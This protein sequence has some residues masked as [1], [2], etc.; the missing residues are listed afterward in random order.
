PVDPSARISS[1]G[2]WVGGGGG[3][4]GRRNRL[5]FLRRGRLASA[6][7]RILPWTSPRTTMARWLAGHGHPI[8]RYRQPP[9]S[10]SPR[11]RAERRRDRRPARHFAHGAL[12]LREG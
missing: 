12:S 1:P 4:R 8:R 5:D 10:L 11:L 9:Q 7:P 2:R 3:G 6:I